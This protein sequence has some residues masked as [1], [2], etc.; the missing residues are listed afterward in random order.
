MRDTKRDISRERSR[1]HAGSP[2]WDSIPGPRDHAL[3]RRQTD[4]QPEPPRDPLWGAF[5]VYLTLPMILMGEK[6]L[7]HT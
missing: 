2:M 6:L 7:I 5:Y 3:S 4:A 1:P